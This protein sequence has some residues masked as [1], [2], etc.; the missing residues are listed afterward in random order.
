MGSSTYSSVRY[1]A[2]SESFKLKSAREIFQEVK[3]S[4]LMDP[5]NI[6]V[7]EARDSEAHPESYPIA[8]FLDNTGSMGKIPEAM[9]K[10]DLGT[11]MET[12][13]GKGLKDAAVMFG[14][15]GDHVFDG[16]PLQVGQFESGDKE[17]TNWLTQ[18]YLEGG[19]GSNN[20]ESYLL[21]WM[22]ASK[23]V[24]ADAF[25]KR[26]KKGCLFTIGDEPTLEKVEADAQKLIFG[27]E[28]AQDASAKGILK[29]AEKHWEVYH[30]HIRQG[31]NGRRAEVINDW[32]KLIGKDNVL[33]ADD[34]TQV[35]TIIADKVLEVTGATNLRSGFKEE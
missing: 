11:L 31:S 24:E 6:K 23:H 32:K 2:T 25:T 8:I 27:T 30:I 29:E 1:A 22:F 19:G 9:V 7:R 16:A 4:N 15:V 33:I 5:K 20:G 34:Y 28:G 18:G 10:E 12:L 21:A 13:I 35:A 26:K 17:L 14:F 3:I